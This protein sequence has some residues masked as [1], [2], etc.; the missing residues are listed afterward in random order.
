MVNDAPSPVCILGRTRKEILQYLA[1][2]AKELNG[3]HLTG[4]LNDRR[5]FVGVIAAPGQINKVNGFKFSD[6][7]VLEYVEERFINIARTR[8]VERANKW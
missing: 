1:V 8:V 3:V 6:L 5:P 7:K 4:T 2:H